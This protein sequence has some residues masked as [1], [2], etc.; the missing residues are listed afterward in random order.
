MLDALRLAV[1]DGDH[2]DDL[3]SLLLVCFAFAAGVGPGHP[4]GV[5][6]HHLGCDHDL[7]SIIAA[8]FLEPGQRLR[9]DQREIV[10]HIA[11]HPVVRQQRVKTFRI[12]RDQLNM[13]AALC[14][15]CVDQHVQLRDELLGNRDIFVLPNAVT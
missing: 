6:P 15:T 14:I 8:Q 13:Q 10:V 5:E 7:L 11:E 12:P 4:A 1:A 9:A 2:A 3:F